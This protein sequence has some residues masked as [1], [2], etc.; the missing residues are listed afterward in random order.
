MNAYHLFESVCACVVCHQ[1][2]MRNSQRQMRGNVR[3]VVPSLLL[4]RPGKMGCSGGYV[5]LTT[6]SSLSDRHAFRA[7][8][9][10]LRPQG[11][12]PGS[13]VC[14]KILRPYAYVFAVVV[15]FLGH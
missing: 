3:G 12:D 2:C 14:D 13:A 4:R 5:S 10:S 7:P 1:R 9:L 11:H 6:D 8:S 15:L